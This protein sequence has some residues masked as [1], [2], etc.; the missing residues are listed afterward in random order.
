M[1][2]IVFPTMGKTWMSENLNSYDFEVPMKARCLSKAEEVASEMGQL[3]QCSDDDVA[4]TTSYI[5]AVKILLDNG[6]IT[7][8][9]VYMILPDSKNQVS[10]RMLARGDSQ[11]KWLDMMNNYEVILHCWKMFARENSISWISTTGY[12]GD[13]FRAFSEANPN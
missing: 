7:C 9:D 5:S 10:A 1:I 4:I 6:T 11:A 3:I 12:C 2:Y 13:I 8:D